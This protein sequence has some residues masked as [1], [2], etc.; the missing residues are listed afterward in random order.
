MTSKYLVLSLWLFIVACGEDAPE[1][2]NCVL[3]KADVSTLAEVD[4]TGP[5]AH[6]SDS[7]PQSYFLDIF[8]ADGTIMRPNL[9]QDGL[10][11]CIGVATP[12]GTWKRVADNRVETRLSGGNPT[13]AEIELIE[14]EVSM[15]G[16]MK[17][18]CKDECLP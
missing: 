3:W 6:H 11:N 2:P 12:I 10:W 18:V 16:D 5:W 9:T 17:V 1:E 14:S 15:G 8:L 7:D 4:F 13:T